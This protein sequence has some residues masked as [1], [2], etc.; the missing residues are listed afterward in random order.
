[1]AGSVIQIWCECEV[2]VWF[3][4]EDDD[5]NNNNIMVEETGRVRKL[6]IEL[7]VLEMGFYKNRNICNY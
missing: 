4:E 1:M 3:D 6:G 2:R 5:D 7:V